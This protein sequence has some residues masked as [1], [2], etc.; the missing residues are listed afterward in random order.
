MNRRIHHI[1]IT[2]LVLAALSVLVAC[3]TP[4][5]QRIECTIEDVY[6]GLLC[7]DPEY[8]DELDQA[9]CEHVC[10]EWQETLPP[11]HPDLGIDC[12]EVSYE[13]V[14][15]TIHSE[16]DIDID[17]EEVILGD[18]TSG[19]THRYSCGAPW[20]ANDYFC[21][22]DVDDD[23]LT[24]PGEGIYLTQTLFHG[25]GTDS[26]AGHQSCI[27]DC[28]D[29]LTY[30]NAVLVAEGITNCSFPVGLCNG[31]NFAY[32]LEGQVCEGAM[33][34]DR[35]GDR[36]ED[37]V[38]SPE[39]GGPDTRPLACSLSGNCCEDFGLGACSNIRLGNRN[40]PIAGKTTALTGTVT[41]TA[42]KKAQPRVIPVTGWIRT[43]SGSCNN[44]AGT[45]PMYLDDLQLDF[46]ERVDNV[47]IDGQRYD[48]SAIDASMDS[49][50]LGV[51]DTRTLSVKLLGDHLPLRISATAAVAN[52]SIRFDEIP[53]MPASADARLNVNGDIVELNAVHAPMGSDATLVIDLVQATSPNG[54]SP[55]G[56]K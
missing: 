10:E 42:S 48:L 54:S 51:L 7:I 29:V 21:P 22:G 9:A 46:P 45:C 44:S 27:D 23:G 1:A 43:S 31:L 28:T 53:A 24:E 6:L 39:D 15:H 47:E 12:S 18:A 8:A 56:S 34:M 32:E 35:A 30:A 36:A 3:E 33:A 49:P 4:P 38:W 37:I 13:N 5:N 41:Y 26:T 16:C 50:T 52:T 17:W 11:G 2:T 14:T 55:G 25:C 19:L 20:A 40:V